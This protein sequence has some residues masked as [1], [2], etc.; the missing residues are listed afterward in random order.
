MRLDITGR[1]VTVTPALR[2]LITQR[3]AALERL[4]NDAA[5]SALVILT[6]E[7]YRHRV[8]IA[9]HAKGDHSLSGTAEAATWALAIRQAALK[10][11]QQ[12]KKLKGKWQARKREAAK[13]SRNRKAGA[14]AAE[15]AASAG[16]TPRV[17]RARYAV[18]PLSIDDAALRLE[19]TDDTF[20]VFRDT[21]DDS[22][23]IMYR[24]K[25]GNLGLIQP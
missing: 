18:K 14:P 22:V 24:R 2:E 5:V 16:D 17:V 4:L 23:A 9:I 21:D 1:H 7:K 10:I 3:L 13:A 25:D 20:V 8:E 11:E 12:A 15:A 6:R 19:R